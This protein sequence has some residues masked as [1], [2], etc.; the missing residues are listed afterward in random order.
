MSDKENLIPEETGLDKV[1]NDVKIIAISGNDSDRIDGTN[2][3]KLFDMFKKLKENKKDVTPIVKAVVNKIA[4]DKDI[5]P[6]IKKEGINSLQGAYATFEKSKSKGSF[7]R[8]IADNR[9]KDMQIYTN[10]KLSND[11]KSMSI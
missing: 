7:R 8:K 10:N 1:I 3:N 9:I 4:E 11:G 5:D 6:Q 2:M